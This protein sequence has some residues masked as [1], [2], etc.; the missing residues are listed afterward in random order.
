MQ[1]LLLP[2][3]STVIKLSCFAFIL[4]SPGRQRPRACP[5]V[6]LPVQPGSSSSPYV[7]R[8]NRPALRLHRLGLHRPARLLPR[9]PA[10]LPSEQRLRWEP[11]CPA[12]SPA[13]PAARSACLP[14]PAWD[15]ASA[16]PPDV[17]GIGDTAPDTSHRRSAPGC[18]LQIGRAHV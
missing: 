4:A 16:T 6:C 5:S 13:P 17:P 8:L 18:P 3:S 12:A 9:L 10:P 14:M 15:I 2:A 1:T 7:L 11:R